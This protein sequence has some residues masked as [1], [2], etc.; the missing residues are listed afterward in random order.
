MTT[1][2]RALDI[3]EPE[4]PFAAA[5]RLPWQRLLALAL[6]LALMG[7][8]VAVLRDEGLARLRGALPVNPLFWIAFAGFYLALPVSEWVIYRRVWQLPAAGL[9]ALLRKLVSNEMLMGYSGELSFY[10]YARREAGL[11]N[12]PFKTIKD[13]SILSA[14]TGN[15]ATLVM[16]AAAFPIW[17]AWE[18]RLLPSG[19]AFSFAVLLAS[20]L[21]LLV[22]RRQIFSL[23]A[24][25]L[26]FI[27]AIHAI[28][29][30]ATTLLLIAMWSA[31]LPAVPLQVWV[32]L[33]AL[34]LVVTRLPLVPNKD[35]VFAGSAL[36]IV[37]DHTKIAALM[38]LIASLLVATHILVGLV[39]VA[40]EL[41]RTEAGAATS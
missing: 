21:V 19:T 14:M 1:A 22:L 37:G 41:T 35:I 4:L 33:A 3:A 38:A 24:A 5:A 18:A 32:G 17:R 11:A 2:A 29:L 30:M 20:S 9:F 16:A 15:V 26:R 27:G 34:Q 23:P 7:P 31:A 10:F 12:S 8:L 25:D 36:L 39:L 13:V 28:R 40:R 6:S